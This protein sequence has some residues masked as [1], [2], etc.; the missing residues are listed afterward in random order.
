MKTWPPCW[1]KSRN[2]SCPLDWPWMLMSPE[3]RQWTGCLGSFAIFPFLHSLHFLQST[4]STGSA[5]PSTP[6]E[7]THAHG[8]LTWL[9]WAAFLWLPNLRRLKS[10]FFWT[11]KYEKYNLNLGVPLFDFDWSCLICRSRSP[12]MCSSPGLSRGWRSWS[13]PHWSGGWTMSLH[14]HSLITLQGGLGWW[15]GSSSGD[16][17]TWYSLLSL[18]NSHFSPF[19][20]HFFVLMCN[21]TFR[22]QIHVLFALC[23]GHSY[24]GPCHQHLRPLQWG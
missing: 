6:G 8:W 18:V 2:M 4:I 24:N 19:F 15:V 21:V 7:G 13:C 12:S 1:V 16:P 9:H 11:S 22:S 5:G 14:S 3:L 17:I 20:Y 10:L 23:N